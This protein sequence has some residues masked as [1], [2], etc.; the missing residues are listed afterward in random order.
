MGCDF[1]FGHLNY[2]PKIHLP[3]RFLKKALLNCRTFLMNCNIPFFNREAQGIV[4]M[5]L[6]GVLFPS[7]TLKAVI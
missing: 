2:E 3:S 4:T 6:P 5:I 1:V 7:K